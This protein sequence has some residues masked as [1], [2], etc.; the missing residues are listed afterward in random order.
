MMESEDM[1]APGGYW[2]QHLLRASRDRRAVG[3]NDTPSW[4]PVKK[5]SWSWIIGRRWQRLRYTDVPAPQ[6]QD[7]YYEYQTNGERARQVLQEQFD[8]QS[9]RQ[10][11]EVPSAKWRTINSP[12]YIT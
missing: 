5:W 4:H 12:S 11:E 6:D 7:P 3:V 9:E 1:Q 10:T 8:D 2:Y